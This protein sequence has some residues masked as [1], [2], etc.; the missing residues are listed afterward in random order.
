[1]IEFRIIADERTGEPV[2]ESP[3]V[4]A[5]LLSTPVFNKGSAFS[6]EERRELG[7]DGLL[8]PHAG[9][10]EEQLDRR[11]K[12]F[13]QLT[14]DLERHI[15]LRALQ[16]R[17]ETL[18]YR[19]MLDRLPE[20][21][22]VI[23]TP[24][25]GMA[26]QLFSH[27]YRQPRGLFIALPDQDRID[28]I[29][30]NRP[31]RDV[32]VI[33]VTDGERIL[34]LG[35]QGV[36]GMGIPV[37]KLSLYTVCGGIHPARTLPIFLDTGT[38]NQDLLGDPLYLGLRHP[39]V[40]GR[41]YDDFIEAFVQAVMRQLPGVL[42]QWED[43]ALGNAR[44]ILERY[45]GRLCTFNDDIQG[46]AAVT[47]GTLLSAIQTTG[48]RLSD[49]R[50]VVLGAGSAAT[51][52]SGLIVSAMVQEGLS[53]ADARARFWLHNRRGLLYTGM[54]GLDAT[55]QLY[56]QPLER[57]AGWQRDAGGGIPPQEVVKQVRPTVLIGVS[58]QP[59]TFAEEVV[60]TM[61]GQ[62][63]RPIIFPLS[64]PTSRSEAVPADLINWTDGRALVATGS[65]F[66]D[67]AY[68][69]RTIPISQCNNSYIF[70][71]LG[72]GVLAAGACRVTDEMFLAA[73]RALRG[74]APTR[75]NSEAS[76]LPPAGEIRQVAR[77]IAL[78]VA[79]AAQAQ[80]VAE[81]TPAEE[82]ERRIDARRWE[83]RYAKMRRRPV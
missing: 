43:F 35:D 41:R 16:D 61:A 54:T 72:L 25:V 11:Y 74:A 69:G 7:L 33:V 82:L 77:Q 44:P 40:R 42:L 79:T 66:P 21:M 76:L 8:P 39:R 64:N 26:C 36:G 28:A 49:Q 24:V 37:G 13:E 56:C 47:L 6:E 34:G 55:Q 22:P 71:G 78:A 29:L 73:A 53:E 5:A 67:V 46:T 19:L 81:T 80:G 50:V 14:S 2:V 38:D 70:P 4:G 51:G 17:N 30:A 15:Y 31:F 18:F 60:R 32:D 9:N 63:E 57:L 59:G 45:R 20:M 27:I 1:M 62:V 58:G 83:P 65:P 23:Y 10:L 12:E 3:F 68:R 75:T 52:I 48:T